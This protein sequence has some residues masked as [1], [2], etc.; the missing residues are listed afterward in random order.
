[1]AIIRVPTI[2]AVYEVKEKQTCLMSFIQ[3]FKT[4]GAAVEW[5]YAKGEKARSYVIQELLKKS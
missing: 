3:D 2:Y 5:I 4:R 1:M